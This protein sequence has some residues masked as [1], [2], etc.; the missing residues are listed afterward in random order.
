MNR[1]ESYSGLLEQKQG[2]Y[3]ALDEL[4]N[5]LLGFAA[6]KPDLDIPKCLILDSLHVSPNSMPFIAP[7][8]SIVFAA[9]ILN[10]L[11]RP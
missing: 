8:D 7:T 10:Q 2:I 11:S 6:I 5:N 9:V 4:S 3:V 1:K